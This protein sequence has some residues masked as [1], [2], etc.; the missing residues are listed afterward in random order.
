MPKLRHSSL[1]LSPDPS[2]VVVR[3]FHIP[4]DAGPLKPEQVSRARRI[5]DAVMAMDMRTCDAELA[6]VN[7]DFG[8]RHWQIHAVHLERYEQIRTELGLENR[9]RGARKALIGAYFCHEYSYAAAALMNPSVVPHPDQS[10]LTGG[11]VRIVMSVRAV[12]EGHISSIAFREGIVTA[13]GEV[14]LLPQPPIA[15]AAHALDPPSGEFPRAQSAPAAT[16]RRPCRA[17]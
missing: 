16:P 13:D 14:T 6:L 3:P 9:L 8:E 4:P 1:R 10:G 7:Q 2:R 17:R 15:M 5:V 11:A 12:G